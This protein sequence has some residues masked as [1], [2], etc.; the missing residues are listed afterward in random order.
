MLRAWLKDIK[1][2]LFFK[3]AKSSPIIIL[4]ALS[5][6]SSDP[7]VEPLSVDDSIKLENLRE[8]N[9]QHAMARQKADDKNSIRNTALYEMALSMGM[10][11]GLYARSKEIN[12]YLAD[13][14]GLLDEIFDFRDLILEDRIIPPVLSEGVKTMDAEAHEPLPTDDDA[15]LLNGNP[16]GQALA[17][18]R[19]RVAR[20]QNNFRTLRITDKYFKIVKQARFAVTVPTWRDYLQM[21]YVKPALPESAILPKTETERDVWADGID[22]GWQLGLSQADQILMQNVLLLRR[23]FLGMLKYRKL[24]AMNMVSKPYVAKRHYGVTGDGD[25]MKVNDR[26]LTIAAL[27]ALKTNS[28]V[29]K[30]ILSQDQEQEV[31]SKLAYLELPKYLKYLPNTSGVGKGVMSKGEAIKK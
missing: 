10:R 11:S 6:C 8:A 17:K 28:K 9:Y 20:A 19:T 7:D 30:P 5:A 27:P 1:I 4:L 21:D 18:A 22:A 2:K 14:G 31:D 25:E 24:L 13:N 26:V 15:F 23:D 29:W 16:T 12:E 3:R